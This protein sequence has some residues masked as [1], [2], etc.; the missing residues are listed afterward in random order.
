[1][2]AYAL[3]TGGSS[4]IGLAIAHELASRKYNLILVSNQEALLQQVAAGLTE[5]YQVQTKAWYMDLSQRE[6]AQRLYDTCKEEQVEIEILVNNAGMFFFGEVVKTEIEKSS[7][8]MMLHT[9]TPAMLCA[10]FG[11]DMKQRQHGHIMNIS[12]ISAWMPYPGIAFYAATKR[13]LK[14]F[15]RSLRTELLDYH[16]NVSCICPGAVSTELY[17]LSEKDRKKALRFGVMMKPEKLAKKA[18]NAMLKRKAMYIPG[19][20]NRLFLLIVPLIPPGLVVFARRHT[21]MLPVDKISQ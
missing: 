7:T 13:F 11:K 3:I 19:F 15:S 8:M 20:L 5:K 10:L 2:A 14:N 16:V 9:H 21:S 6:A 12:S 18:V 4:G 17:Q 1:M